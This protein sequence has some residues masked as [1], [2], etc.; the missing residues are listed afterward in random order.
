MAPTSTSAHTGAPDRAAGA[1][2]SAGGPTAAHDFVSLSSQTIRPRDYDAASYIPGEHTPTSSSSV[3]RFFAAVVEGV[4]S[5]RDPEVTARRLPPIHFPYVQFHD[6][7]PNALQQINNTP[8][9]LLETRGQ[10]GL[11]YDRS[12][13]VATMARVGSYPWSPLRVDALHSDKHIVWF[14][15]RSNTWNI[16][17]RDEAYAVC[18]RL[19]QQQAPGFNSPRDYTVGVPQAWAIVRAH[20]F[21]GAS[22]MAVVHR[23]TGAVLY[24][25]QGVERPTDVEGWRL[26]DA[27]YFYDYPGA[28]VRNYRKPSESEMAALS[29][30]KQDV[31]IVAI[32]NNVTRE[33]AYSAPGFVLQCPRLGANA[34]FPSHVPQ[35]PQRWILTAHPISPFKEAASPQGAEPAPSKTRRAGEPVIEVSPACHPNRPC[36]AL[37]TG[38]GERPDVATITND[39]SMF[40][41][42]GGSNKWFQIPRESRPRTPR[43]IDS[44]QRPVTDAKPIRLNGLEGSVPV[45]WVRE[46]NGRVLEQQAGVSVTQLNGRWNVSLA[47][48]QFFY[49]YPGAAADGYGKPSARDSLSVPGRADHDLHVLAVVNRVT[50]QPIYIAPGFYLERELQRDSHGAERRDALPV[51]VLRVPQDRRSGQFQDFRDGILQGR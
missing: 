20:D 12:E 26:R 16:R 15:G 23:A 33:P 11:P 39:R 40:W 43:F 28:A 48:A 31:R 7:E 38:I 35:N 5:L 30:T 8:R 47:D 2:P 34:R 19:I 14:D 29:I 42:D 45:A 17:G 49:G 9:V 21:P 51:W 10:P 44:M 1:T 37:T 24:Q 25:A 3:A 50:N 13:P 32:V 18:E 41:Y 36:F 46:G 4:R 27:T 22:V 6:G